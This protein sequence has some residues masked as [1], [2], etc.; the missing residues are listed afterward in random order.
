MKAL[1]NYVL[2][3][4]DRHSHHSEI[5]DIQSPPYSY[6]T[7]IDRSSIMEWEQNKKKNLTNGEELVVLNYVKL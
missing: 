5:L 1:V 7:Y 2:Q 3:N 4:N 6:S